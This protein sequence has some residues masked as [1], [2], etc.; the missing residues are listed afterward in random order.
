MN[1]T[2][3]QPKPDGVWALATGSWRRPL[4]HGTVVPSP[5]GDGSY[6]VVDWRDHVVGRAPSLETA[7]QILEERAAAQEVTQAMLEGV[8]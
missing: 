5:T 7:K 6:T 1:F 8:R 4:P 3:W 2:F